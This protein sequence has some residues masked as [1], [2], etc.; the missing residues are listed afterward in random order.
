MLE[1]LTGLGLAL[2]AGLNAYIPLLAIGVTARFTSLV[3]L[4]PPYDFLASDLGLAILAVLL[5]IEVVADKVVIVDHINDLIQTFIRPAAGAVLV[6]ASTSAVD[7]INP[8]LSL[9]LGIIAAGS[10]HATKAAARPAVTATTGGVGNPIV[11]AAEDG[12]AVIASLVAILFPL[13]VIVF[14]VAFIVTGV[15]V[16]RSVRRR[17]RGASP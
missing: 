16:L 2:P 17:T 5:A 3:T 13:L 8:A 15:Y 12:V 7:E 1:L 14:L 11:S 9:M 10:V 6:L 4:A